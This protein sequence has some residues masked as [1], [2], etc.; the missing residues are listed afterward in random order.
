VR[1]DLPRYHR[2]SWDV[3]EAL[4]AA[5][6]AGDPT[7]ELFFSTGLYNFARGTIEPWEQFFSVVTPGDVEDGMLPGWPLRF[8]FNPGDQ[9]YGFGAP[10]IGDIDGDGQREMVVGTGMCPDL[11]TSH[12]CLGVLALRPDG[13]VVP[14]FP[15]PA[16]AFGASPNTTPALGDLD[17][18]GQIEVVWLDID[19]LL[20]V[21]EVPGASGPPDLPWPMARR[22]PA[23]TGGPE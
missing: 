16:Q 21:W 8:A 11:F 5:D 9:R 12:R 17:N 7:P 22:N 20:S 15:K 18:D 23:H 2:H 10:A 14:G 19:G 13:S 1:F 6:V 4:V 3:L